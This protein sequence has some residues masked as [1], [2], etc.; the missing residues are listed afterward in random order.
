MITLKL[1]YGTASN[2]INFITIDGISSNSG[3]IFL[4]HGD[5]YRETWT[6]LNEKSKALRF[7]A[8]FDH[9]R[10]SYQLGEIITVSPKVKTCDILDLKFDSVKLAD[11]FC[12]KLSNELENISILHFTGKSSNIRYKRRTWGKP[13]TL[14]FSKTH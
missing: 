8:A 14:A 10:N 5:V 9:I 11:L 3:Q 1:T 2:R 6:N 4:E 12:Q 7:K 13:H